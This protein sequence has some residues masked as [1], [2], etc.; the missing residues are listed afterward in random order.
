MSKRTTTNESSD[1][2][3]SKYQGQRALGAWQEVVWRHNEKRKC[4][5]IE[6]LHDIVLTVHSRSEWDI[7]VFLPRVILLFVLQQIQV[8]ADHLPGQRWLNDVIH[9][10]YT[11]KTGNRKQEVALPLVVTSLPNG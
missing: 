2:S 6:V 3:S 1:P 7:A 9:K 8:T 4:I 10:T 5:L 11:H